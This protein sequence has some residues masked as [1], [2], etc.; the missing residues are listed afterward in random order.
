[1]TRLL[2]RRHHAVG[3]DGDDA[4][5]LRE[6]DLVLADLALAVRDHRLDDVASEVRVL[7]ATWRNL[8]AR[9]G[10]PDDLV[11]VLLD[12]VLLEEVLALLVAG[13]VEHG[14]AERLHRA[15]DREEDGVAEASAD[16]HHR[17]VGLHL[18]GRSGRSHSG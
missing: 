3:A 12:V 2:H 14:G 10:A 11:G 13:E 1:M 8:D 17:L 18:G 7:R 6:L 9:V 15:S 16:E 4:R 5:D